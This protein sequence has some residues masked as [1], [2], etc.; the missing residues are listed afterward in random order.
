MKLEMDVWIN[1]HGEIH[2]TCEDPRLEKGINIRAKDNLES[3]RV[4]R[5]ALEAEQLATEQR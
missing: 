4:L 1:A 2:L 3:T 5:K